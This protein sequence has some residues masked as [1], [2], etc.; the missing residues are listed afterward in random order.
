M[1]KEKFQQISEEINSIK[2]FNAETYE[3]YRKTV[4]Y[5]RSILENLKQQ[6]SDPML[7]VWIEMGIQELAN[8]IQ[9]RMGESFAGL[10]KEHQKV[11]F[12]Y[13]RSTVSLTLSN[14]ILNLK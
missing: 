1:I 8:E 14:I 13:S 6:S 12:M 10:D 5:L 9:N 3:S 4:I 7:N 2:V 11:V